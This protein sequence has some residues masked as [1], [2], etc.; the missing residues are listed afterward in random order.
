[1]LPVAEPAA[2]R[3]LAG[4]LALVALAAVGTQFAVVLP[5]RAD[6]SEP[7]ARVWYMARYFTILT[8]LLIAGLFLAVALGRRP[9]P[10]AM[11]SGVVAIVMVG[12]VYHLLLAPAEPHRGLQWWTDFGYHTLTPVGCVLWWLA[13]GGN[14]LRLRRL[15]LW[16]AWPL[17]YCLYAMARGAVEGRYPYFF[18]NLD[19]LG[20]AGVAGWI[21]TLMAAFAVAGTSVWLIARLSGRDARL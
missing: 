6:L 5:T 9:G 19:R 7:L 18:L 15:P 1:V 17:G 14:G 3:A 4:A 13:W 20:A 2:S 16:L 21:A 11:A 8:N 12:L 10:D